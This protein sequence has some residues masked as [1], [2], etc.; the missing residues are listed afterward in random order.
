MRFSVGVPC[1]ALYCVD[2]LLGRR[3]VVG[4]VVGVAVV[5]RAGEEEPG[6]RLGRRS[7]EDLLDL[8]LVHALGQGLAD[9]EVVGRGGDRVFS[10]MKAK[11]G[12]PMT[13]VW[14]STSWYPLPPEPEKLVMVVGSIDWIMSTPPDRSVDSRW[15]V[16]GMG[17]KV[18]ESR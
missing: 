12:W 8:G 16:S 4:G 6:G 17:L 2:Q 13:P 3:R 15:V 11:V 10:M 5:G 1:W 14:L 18:I 9:A 7:A